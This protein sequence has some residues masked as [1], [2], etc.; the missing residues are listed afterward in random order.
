[1]PQQIINKAR[2]LLGNAGGE[3]FWRAYGLTY[4]VAWCAIFVWY[5]FQACGLAEL[6]YDGQKTAYVPTLWNWAKNKK[7]TVTDPQP[8]DLVI[9]DWNKNGAADHVGIVERVTDTTLYTLEGNADD[10]ARAM[11]R[12]RNDQVMGY[13]RPPYPSTVSRMCNSDECPIIASLKTII[14]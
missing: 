5:V 2:S 3:L 13:I 7:L 4:R 1:M 14:N 10:A 9:F 12:P 6:F 8:G 11:T